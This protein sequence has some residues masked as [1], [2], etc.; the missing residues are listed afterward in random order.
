MRRSAAL[1]FFILLLAAFACNFPGLAAAP[2]A[3]PSTRTATIKEIVNH[4]VAR[5]QEGAAESPAALDQMV[6]VGGQVETKEESK[7]KLDLSE[8][9]SIVR[10]GP[11]TTFTVKELSANENGPVSRFYLYA[12]KMWIVLSES[13]GGEGIV[14]TPTGVASVR[15]SAMSVEYYA[16]YAGTGAP[17]MVVT[18]LT[19]VCSASNAFNGTAL[20]PGNNIGQQAEIVGN[21]AGPGA[22]HD[23]DPAQLADWNAN[24]PEIGASATPGGAPQ[25]DTVTPPPTNT[26][27]P[28]VTPPT[29]TPTPPPTDTP[30]PT[31]TPS[32]TPLGPP[33]ITVTTDANVRT[34]PG[35]VYP[36]LGGL[37]KGATANVLGQ[38]AAKTWFVIVFPAATDGRGWIWG[39]LVTLGGDTS[40]IP[41]VAAPPTP[42]FTPTNTFTPTFTFTPS[43]TVPS[44]TPSITSIP[45]PTIDAKPNPV[46][47]INCAFKGGF[48]STISW[49]APG[50]TLVTIDALGTQPQPVS[51]SQG[52]CLRASQT[53]TLN[54]SYPDGSK[55]S[56]AVTVTV[57]LPTP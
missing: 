19:G 43:P 8:S 45:N 24:V 35:Q 34:G 14:E 6:P 11:Q 3:G 40:N 1:A 5:A 48:N 41:I 33:F 23:M 44:P 31:V 10:L 29:D 12:G 46:T 21:N 56:A 57:A 22:A 55:K 36:V 13:G 26:F 16:N 15:G 49:S 51:G 4:V 2:T 54:A 7:A 27:A 25:A 38:D 52:I 18:C 42:T 28:G 30:S 17:L 50:A 39:K 47:D 9:G 20:T 37:K 53:Y 32:P